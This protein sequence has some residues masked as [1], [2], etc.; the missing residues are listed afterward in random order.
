VTSLYAQDAWNPTTRLGVTGG[1]RL[2]HYGDVG[3]TLQPRLA[4]VYRF[5]RDFT[6][7]AGYARGARPPSFLELFYSSP[8]YRANASSTSCAATA[9]TRRCSSGARGCASPSPAIARGSGTRSRRRRKG[10]RPSARRPPVFRNL[11]RIDAFGADLEASR[12]FAGQRSGRARLFPPAR[13]RRR[14]RPPAGRDPDLPRRLYGTFPAGKYFTLSPSLTLRGSRPRAEGDLRPELGGYALVDLAARIHN[15][16]R[17]LEF[18]VVLHD[19]FGKDYF[20]PAPAGLPG[21]YP[22]PGFS[23]FIKAKYRF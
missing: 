5:P 8:A 10:S 11:D 14:D 19:L 6:V 16:H 13:R 4:G 15:F 7:K 23:L 17:A 20:D 2:D 9:W 1:L 3:G 22:R 18:S 12:T 21:D